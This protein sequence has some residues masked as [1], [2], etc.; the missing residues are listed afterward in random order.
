M[1]YKPF[2]RLSE[3]DEEFLM[4]GQSNQEPGQESHQ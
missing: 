1:I 3:F 2:F 4:Q